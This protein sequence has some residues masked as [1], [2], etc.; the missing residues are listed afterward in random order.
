VYLCNKMI[1]PYKLFPF[2]LLGPKGIKNLPVDKKK[3]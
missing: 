3:F 1:T 2:F